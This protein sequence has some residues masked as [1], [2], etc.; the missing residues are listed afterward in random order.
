MNPCNRLVEIA[1]ELGVLP[2]ANFVLEHPRF[3]IWSACSRPDKHHYG[4]GGLAEHTLE[5]VELC[6]Q[7]NRYFKA[8][9]KA[10][11]DGKLFLA[12]LFHDF[13]KI[14]DY[15]PNEDFSEWRKTLHKENV[16][17]ISKSGIMWSKACVACDYVDEDDEVLHAILSHH[18]LREWGSPVAPNTRMAWILHLSDSISARVDDCMK[19]NKNG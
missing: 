4:K 6:L 18:G 7:N 19:R 13:G 2:L 8:K 16:H 14:F 1:K 15:Q 3:P 10:V 11:D 17:H 12:A 5:V 9:G